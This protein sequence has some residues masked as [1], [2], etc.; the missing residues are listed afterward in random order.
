MRNPELIRNLWLE[1]TPHRLIATPIVLIA[2]FYLMYKI[3]GPFNASGVVA[4]TAF[5]VFAFF[6]FIWGTHC[7]ANAVTE[8]IN[9]HTW[10]WQRTSAIK[11][12]TMSIGKLL[13]STS[14]TWF[15]AAIALFAFMWFSSAQAGTENLG[16]RVLILILGAL[17]THALALLFSVEALSYERHQKVRSFKY[18][19]ISLIIGGTLTYSTYIANSSLNFVDKMQWHSNT[20]HTGTFY[21][22]SLIIFFA[23]SILGVY[24]NMRLELQHRNIPWVWGAFTLFCMVYY[25]GFA[26]FKPDLGFD[27]LEDAQKVVRNSPL[28]TAFLVG[29]FLTYIS[30]LSENIG[31]LRYQKALS[32]LKFKGILDA[33]ERLPRWPV[34][35]GLVVIV[36]LWL[37]TTTGFEIEHVV[38]KPFVFAISF[39]LFMLRDVLI[40]HY[41]HFGKKIKRGTI[42]TIFYF[43][44][45]YFLVPMILK[46]LHFG[47][48]AACFWPNFGSEPVASIFGALVQVCIIGYLVYSRWHEN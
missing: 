31:K 22:S 1:F 11:P 44:I 10:D 26:S 23:W 27:R 5:Y 9:N 12:F 21:F 35:F 18:F 8:E 47:T 33:L 36:G 45:L 28:Y 6:S 15:G 7:A 38:F 39:I 16:S 34:S 32:A 2:L 17:F 43:L 24:R 37:G 19:L 46:V 29:A 25:S 4:N 48:L 41:F 3:S 42:T 13:G 20:Y 40:C 30:F 14:F